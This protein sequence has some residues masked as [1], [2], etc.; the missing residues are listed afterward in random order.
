MG[1]EVLNLLRFRRGSLRFRQFFF[2]LALECGSSLG[3]RLLGGNLLGSGLLSGSLLSGGLLSGGLLSGGLLSGGLLSGGLLSGGLLGGG[4]F[5]IGGW[6]WRSIPPPWR[7]GNPSLA[8]RS[9]PL[10]TGRSRSRDSL[11]LSPAL[12]RRTGITL[13]WHHHQYCTGLLIPVDRPR[14]GSYCSSGTL[15]SLS[16]FCSGGKSSSTRS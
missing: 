14:Q 1:G 10:A 7:N 2:G 4:R 9:L 12:L 11:A 5:P 16:G 13:I 8:G 6:R 15:C 3:S